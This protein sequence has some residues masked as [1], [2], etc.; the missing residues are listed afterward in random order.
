MPAPPNR[1]KKKWY[2]AEIR[3]INKD[4]TYKCRFL[5]YNYIVEKAEYG[6]SLRLVS[7]PLMPRVVHGLKKYLAH[8][9]NKVSEKKA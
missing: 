1:F 2:A 7:W 3:S 9:R 8:I 6:T 5:R 4:G